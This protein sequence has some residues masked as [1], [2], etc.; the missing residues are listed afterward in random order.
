M[1]LTNSDPPSIRDSDFLRPW[2]V[3]ARVVDSLGRH[4]MEGTERAVKGHVFEELGGL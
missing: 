3:R 2:A 4:F 1:S